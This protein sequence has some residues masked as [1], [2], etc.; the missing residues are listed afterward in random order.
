MTNH[1]VR[2]YALVVVLAVFFVSWA[3]IAAHP[4]KAEAAAAKDPR[5]VRLAKREHKLRH[6]AARVNKIVNHRWA[7]YQR[8]LKHRKALNHEISVQNQ[9]AASAPVQVVTLPAPSSSVTSTRTS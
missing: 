9:Q 6:E 2:I 1:A 3:A 4:W 7:V 5:L 8:E